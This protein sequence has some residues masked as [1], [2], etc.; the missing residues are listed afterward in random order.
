M[1]QGELRGPHPASP[2][3]SCTSLK[4]RLSP[5][6][7]LSVAAAA[8]Q[9]CVRSASTIARPLLIDSVTLQIGQCRGVMVLAIRSVPLRALMRSR[10]LQTGR[11]I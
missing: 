8:T 1:M 7:E 4:P 5:Q 6:T 10:R 3:N 9:Y 2:E 11:A